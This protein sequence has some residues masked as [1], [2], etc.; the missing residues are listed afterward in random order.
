MPVLVEGVAAQT[1]DLHKKLD[2]IAK[3]VEAALGATQAVYTLNGL[4]RPLSLIHI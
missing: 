2:T 3:E 4:A 1:S